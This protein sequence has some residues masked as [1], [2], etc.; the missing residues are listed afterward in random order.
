M[1]I[2][3]DSRCSITVSGERGRVQEPDLVISTIFMQASFISWNWVLV[4]RLGF[5]RWSKDEMR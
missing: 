2:V 5:L 1:R 4:F 3:L